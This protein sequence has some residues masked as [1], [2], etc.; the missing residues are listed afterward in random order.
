MQH[1]IWTSLYTDRISSEKSSRCYVSKYSTHTPL[2]R[3]LLEVLLEAGLV[4]ELTEAVGAL[5]RHSLGAAPSAAGP[6]APCTS[7]VRSLHMVVEE[8]LLGKVL[9]ETR[10]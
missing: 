1:E 3:L 10:I 6:S 9:R 2:T 5:E 8:A 7:S 4:G